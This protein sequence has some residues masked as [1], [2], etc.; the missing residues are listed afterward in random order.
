MKSSKKPASK[1]S[2]AA[3]MGMTEAEHRAMKGSMKGGK[4]KPMKSGRKMGY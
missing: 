2:P 1:K 3:R 4:G